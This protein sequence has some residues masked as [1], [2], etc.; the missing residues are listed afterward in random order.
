MP[1]FAKVC[2]LLCI[3]LAA[4]LGMGGCF[5]MADALLAAGFVTGGERGS[6]FAPEAA[7]DAGAFLGLGFGLFLGV[8]AG[9]FTRFG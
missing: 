9:L 3:L 5:F 1:D 4:S 7:G 8:A 2:N 6:C